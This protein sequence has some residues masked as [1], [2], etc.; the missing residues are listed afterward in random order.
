VITK[1]GQS[2]PYKQLWYF[3]S[4]NVPSTPT[5]QDER[6]ALLMRELQTFSRYRRREFTA[7]TSADK[8]VGNFDQKYPYRPTTFTV[9]FVC[10]QLFA[11]HDAATPHRF[12]RM[13]SGHVP[14][15]MTNQRAVSKN[16]TKGSIIFACRQCELLTLWGAIEGC[17][18]LFLL[19]SSAERALTAKC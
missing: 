9:L 18:W 15:M 5:S 8:F 10:R 13:R 4:Q 7:S 1:H 12:V 16:S 3:W 17:F 14:R 11:N 6:L 2:K 19:P